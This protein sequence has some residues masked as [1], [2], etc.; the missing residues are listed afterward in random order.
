M[1]TKI[2]EL[3]ERDFRRPIE[4]IIKV[5]NADEETVYT[6]L[7]EY[8]A[9]DRIKSEYERLFR[10]MADAPKTPNEGVGVWISGFFGSGKSS[11]AKN[12][13]YVLANRTVLGKSASA[14]FLAQ[15]GHK[16]ITNFVEFL[17][18]SIPCEVFMFDVQ[19]D[20]SV[21]TN[22]ERIAEVMYRVLLRELDYSEDYDVAD[23]EIE[24]EREK[25]LDTLID[26]CE[27]RYQ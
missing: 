12:L 26:L 6:E 22:A 16:N 3:L 4:E 20:L 19:V 7:T 15:V 25:K 14:L 27:K 2:G 23:L 1:M 5:S 17:N 21:Q 13:G 8:I 9:T 18:S 11:F 24:L 10:A